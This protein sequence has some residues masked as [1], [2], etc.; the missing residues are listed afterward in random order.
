MGVLAALFLGAF[1][2][3]FHPSLKHVGLI[4]GGLIATAFFIDLLLHVA[5]DWRGG[6]TMTAQDVVSAALIAIS[7]SSV[8]AVGGLIWQWMWPSE[9]KVAIVDSAPS[10]PWTDE[11]S[12]WSVSI[13]TLPL[14]RFIPDKKIVVFQQFRLVNVSTTHKRIIDLEIVV[15][16]NGDLA[17]GMSFKTEFYRESGY[18]QMLKEAGTEISSRGWAFLDSPIELQPGQMVEGQIDFILPDSIVP[19][20]IADPTRLRMESTTISVIDRISGNRLELLLGEHYNAIKRERTDPR[21]SNAPD[22]GLFRP[23]FPEPVPGKPRPPGTRPEDVTFSDLLM[24]EFPNMSAMISERVEKGSLAYSKFAEFLVLQ[25]NVSRSEF[26]AIYTT[27][28]AQTFD[29]CKWFVE[30]YR[31]IREEWRP[32][33]PQEKGLGVEPYG[34]NNDFPFTGQFYIYHEGELDEKQQQEL[35]NLYQTKGLNVTF[36]GPK[37]LKEKKEWLGPR[38][39]K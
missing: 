7:L 24:F 26:Y 29:V 30:N 14:F 8:V 31:A 22:S 38:L 12:E 13:E 9:E 15:P 35:W 2:G 27:E 5:K 11:V 17:P 25:D 21:H 4:V 39:H 36:R 34:A 19:V 32:A 1:A 3:E 6:K 10:K 18:R 28:N 37:Y 23:V 20:V 16:P 33:K